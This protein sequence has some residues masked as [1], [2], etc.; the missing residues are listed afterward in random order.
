MKPCNINPW[1]SPI[2]WCCLDATSVQV[3]YEV[4]RR[5]RFRGDH[6]QSLD[7]A[8]CCLL[9]FTTSDEIRG[10]NCE[11]GLLGSFQQGRMLV[12]QISDSVQKPSVP[13]WKTQGLWE[14]DRSTGVKVLVHSTALLKHMSDGRN[15]K[16]PHLSS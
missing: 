4:A 15:P 11:N 8:W 5:W 2:F 12:Y 9:V 1:K 3:R 10:L 13:P 14:Q 7:V 16:E 6:Q